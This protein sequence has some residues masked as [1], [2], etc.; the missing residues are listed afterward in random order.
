M[1][2]QPSH[3]IAFF[4]YPACH[5]RPERHRDESDRTNAYIE[6]LKRENARLRAEASAAQSRVTKLRRDVTKQRLNIERRKDRDDV[7]IEHAIEL[8][9]RNV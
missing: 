2:K 9:A 8:Y 7:V 1:Q 4:D 5:E 6:R 3:T